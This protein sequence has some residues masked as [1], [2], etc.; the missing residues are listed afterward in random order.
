MPSKSKEKVP[1]IQKLLEKVISFEDS[2]AYSAIFKILEPIIYNNIK[3]KNID[4]YDFYN[5]LFS[6]FWSNKSGK[7]K[8][9]ASYKKLIEKI[10][11]GDIKSN[12]EQ[13][14]WFKNYCSVIIRGTAISEYLKELN[15]VDSQSP[16]VSRKQETPDGSF[17]DIIEYFINKKE[18][19]KAKNNNIINIIYLHET[20][21]IIEDALNSM[22]EKD[23]VPLILKSKPLYEIIG[24]SD[25]QMNWLSEI[26]S[27]PNE[28]LEKILDDESQKNHDKKFLFSSNFIAKLINI[29][30]NTV[31]KRV[32]RS[33]EKL[34]N[35]LNP[36]DLL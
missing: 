21:K 9:F 7:N 26:S 18:G 4:K 16:I 35:L 5:W 6:W 19:K 13:L 27:I 20:F 17:I 1:S 12:E 28:E 23:A 22:K 14:T 30:S 25:K 3:G 24:L 33:L 34:R 31:D 36:E 11:N 29:K 2:K 32:V 15:T 10:D 8:F